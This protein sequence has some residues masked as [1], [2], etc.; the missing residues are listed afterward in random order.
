MPL[1]EFRKKIDILD[2]KIVEFLNQRARICEEIGK[3]KTKNKAGVYVSSREREVIK[4]VKRC[5]K[6]PMSDEA[7]EAVYR[8]IMSASLSL[9]KSLQIAFLGPE[10]SF[11]NFAAVRKFGSQVAYVP[12]GTI[13]E[14]FEKVESGD[15][16]YGV[17][18]IENS[19]EGAVTNT[20]DLMADSDLKI[21]AHLTMEIS[22]SLLSNSP[23]EKIEKVY[24]KFEV[25]GQC[26]HWLQEHL[27]HAEQIEVASTTKAAKIVTKEKNAAAIASLLAADLYHL[28][29]LK[30]GIEDSSQNITRFLVIAKNDALPTGEDRTSILFS[31]RDKVGALHAMLTPF[32][33]NGI[34]LTKIESRP[35]KKKAWDYYFFVDFEGHREDPKIK[36]ALERLED[37]C[38]FLKILGSYPR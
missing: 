35:S 3:S 32:F 38:K 29:V 21:C 19:I 9:E 8:E 34:N 30:K 36:K 26:R 31:I 1:N 10:A 2:E 20:F 4:N 28:H 33:E 12:T 13:S 37:M 14:V 23:M 22:H 25:F 17:V 15:A 6:G 18:P 11:T 24:S 16:D 27:P 5:N 7:L